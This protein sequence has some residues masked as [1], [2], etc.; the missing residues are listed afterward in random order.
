MILSSCM[1]TWKCRKQPQTSKLSTEAAYKSMSA[2]CFEII[3]YEGCYQNSTSKWKNQPHC[4]EKLLE[5]SEQKPTPFIMK[6]PSSYKYIS[7]KD[8]SIN[9][10]YISSK[11]LFTK[12]ML[13]RRYNYLLSKLMLCDTHH[14]FEGGC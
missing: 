1:I 7:S 10:Q 13:R 5:Q 8:Q 3:G 14:L 9:L 12:V 4:M 6:I 2:A 11:Y